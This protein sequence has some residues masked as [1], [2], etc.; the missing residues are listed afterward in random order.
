MANP[1]KRGVGERTLPLRVRERLEK[2]R[3]ARRERD[4][5]FDARDERLWRLIDRHVRAEEHSV[6]LLV[7]RMDRR[8]L[9]TPKKA[10]RQ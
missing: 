2:W 4:L 8:E 6:T 1:T 3:T 5:A 7:D 9:P 10:R